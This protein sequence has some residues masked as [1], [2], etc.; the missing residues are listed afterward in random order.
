MI[1][2]DALPTKIEPGF[3]QPRLEGARDSYS[4]DSNPQLPGTQPCLDLFRC[5]LSDRIIV[6][7]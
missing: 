3:C 2:D 5:V 6:T 7:A 1:S 4:Q